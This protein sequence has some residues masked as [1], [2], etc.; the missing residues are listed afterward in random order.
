MSGYPDLQ[1]F[2]TLSQYIDDSHITF[3]NNIQFTNVINVTKNVN[4][5]FVTPP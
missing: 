2:N 4:R 3:L 5:Q 1:H